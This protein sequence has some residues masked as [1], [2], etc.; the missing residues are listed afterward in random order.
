MAIV[1]V[2]SEMGTAR[3]IW[4]SAGLVAS[5]SFTPSH[6]TRT[7]MEVAVVV[8]RAQHRSQVGL[9]GSGAQSSSHPGAEG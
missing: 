5:D 4:R 3:C 1:E 9:V 6:L 2:D 8:V 7:T